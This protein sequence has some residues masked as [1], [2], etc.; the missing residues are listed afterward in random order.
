MAE[1]HRKRWPM[2]EKLGTRRS[3]YISAIQAVD[4]AKTQA[5]YTSSAIKN[6]AV[7]HFLE[8]DVL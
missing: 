6:M 8:I 7:D 4:A 1:R 5:V 3:R 2:C